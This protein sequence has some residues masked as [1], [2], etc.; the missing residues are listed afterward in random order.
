MGD[1]SPVA[2]QCDGMDNDCNGQ[3]DDGNPGGG[4]S[5]MTGLSGVC[6]VGTNTCTNGA[7]KCIQ[8]TMA[9]TEVCD[10]LD[11]DCNGMLDDGNPGGGM[12]CMTGNQGACA[13]GTTTCTTGMIVCNQTTMPTAEKCDNVDNDCNGMVDDMAMGV[14]VACNTGMPGV[15]AAG[16]TTCTGGAIVCT[17]NT[18]ASAEMCDGLDNDCDGTVD[19]GNPGGGV[20]CGPSLGACTTQTACVAGAIVCRGTFVGPMGVGAA[21]NPGTQAQPVLTIAAAQANAAIIGGGADVCVCDTAAAG[22]SIYSEDVTMVEGTSVLG[23]YNCADWS[24]NITTYITT[25]QNTALTGVKFPAGITA[26]T[27]LD[28][29]TVQGLAANMGTSAA[30]TVTDSSPSLLTVT[31]TGGQAPT[32]IGLNVSSVNGGMVSPTVNGGTYSAIAVGNGST[33]TAVNLAKASGNFTNVTM[34]GAPAAGGNAATTSVGLRCTDCPGTTI[35]GGA[36]NGVLAATTV[37]GIWASGNVAGL[38]VTNTNVSGG[39]VTNAAGNGYGARL[40]TCT[41]ASTFTTANILGG[42][43]ANGSRF[44]V[45]ST[46][47]MCSPAISGGTVRGC[48][49]GTNCTGISCAT[50]S[51]CTAT[52]ATIRGASAAAATTAY[53]VRCASNACGTFSGNTITV[54][55]MGNNATTGMGIDIVGTNPTFDDNDISSPSCPNGVGGNPRLYGA[56]FSNTSSLATN[57][58]IHDQTCLSQIDV[59]RF[60]KLSSGAVVLGPTIHSNTI[61]FTTCNG[62]GA[63]RGLVIAAQAGAITPASGIVR[64]NIFRNVG[65]ANQ[66]TGFAVRENDTQSDL[67]FFENNDLWMP[68]G[69]ALYFDEGVTPLLLVAINALTGSTANINADPQLDA[70]YHLL[71][72]SPCRNAGTATGAPALDFDANMRP[73]EMVYDIG[74]DEYVP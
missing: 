28:G 66:N 39:Q 23:G 55:T 46:G 12:A 62:C 71:M 40:E 6:A 67:S 61:Q 54:A 68:G 74:A 47:A 32:S 16:T 17:P 14:G 15:C 73:Q 70:T 37:A 4:A 35:T 7:I 64:N 8:N 11:N 34:T 45:D 29:I 63:K 36:I 27:A 24:R 1:V 52:N 21:G 5:C 13:A 42:T 57:N 69:G 53:G 19:N 18:M 26:I 58:I 30:I 2:E 48:E 56:H 41:G 3:A 33:Q 72:A 49:S 60:D 38:T 9:S 44:G 10:G 59:V 50:G 43:G 31:A 25:I 22:A 65:M 20:M 51:L